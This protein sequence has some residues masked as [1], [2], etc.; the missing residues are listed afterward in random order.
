[1][2]Q[3]ILSKETAIMSGKTNDMHHSTIGQCS[4]TK[5][6]PGY[7]VLCGSVKPEVYETVNNVYQFVNHQK[8]AFYDQQRTSE[9]D[10]KKP[11]TSESA[12]PAIAHALEVNLDLPIGSDSPRSTSSRSETALSLAGYSVQSRPDE[13]GIVQRSEAPSPCWADPRHEEPHSRSNS[14]SV[15]TNRSERKCKI[16]KIDFHHETLHSTGGKCKKPR[17][18][19]TAF[20]DLQLHELE[21]IFDRQKYLSVQDRME[22]AERLQLTDTQVKTW[23]QNRRTKWKRQTAVGFELLAEAGNFVAVQR[24]LQTNSYWAYHPAAQAILASMKAMV[25]KPTE[26][27]EECNNQQDKCTNQ[28]RPVDKNLKFGLLEQNDPNEPNLSLSD[29]AADEP[30][31]ESTKLSLATLVTAPG[32]H[33]PKTNSK[34]LDNV[35]YEAVP[36]DTTGMLSSCDTKAC[37]PKQTFNTGFD[38]SLKSGDFFL[39]IPEYFA[40]YVRNSSD[41]PPVGSVRNNFDQPTDGG[42]LSSHKPTLPTCVTTPMDFHFPLFT[43]PQSNFIQSGR[44]VTADSQFTRSCHEQKLTFPLVPNMEQNIFSHFLTS[45]HPAFSKS[46]TL[47][48]QSRTMEQLMSIASMNQLR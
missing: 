33:A 34:Q 46:I 45:N 20:T 44:S 42:L 36:K 32:Q 17:K 21:K 12:C 39:D 5:Y 29:A 16:R 48:E 35:P 43:C 37:A 47:T 41:L 15:D 8:R 1:M 38:Y 24:I 26:A 4:N 11:S 10:T 28:Q 9:D 19:R 23:Y 7:Q 31:T 14:E 13:H 2:I 18:A 6:L 40:K 3:D 25:K 30:S 27:V 22:L